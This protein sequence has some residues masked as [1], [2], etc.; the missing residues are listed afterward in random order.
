ARENVRFGLERWIDYMT[1][2]AALPLGAPPGVDPVDYMISTG[3]AVIG[4]P[5][6]F[7]QQME[8]LSEQ[9]GGFGCFLCLDHHWA[10]R[11][12][13]HRSYEL[14]ARFAIPKINRL[15]Q[16]RLDS[17]RWLR[18]NNAQFKGE[19]NAAVRAKMEEHARKQGGG[20]QLSPEL[21]EYFD[22]VTGRKESA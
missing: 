17:E 18:E 1:Q 21:V 4:T 20:E 9:S 16:H 13:T 2:V 14:I 8:R 22:Q 15:N 19:L 5:D 3:F 6:D 7:V 11:A 10:D 12:E